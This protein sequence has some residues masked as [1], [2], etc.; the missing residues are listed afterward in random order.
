MMKQPP[1]RPL[2][3]VVPYPPEAAAAYRAAGAWQPG[4]IPQRLR[5]VAAAHGPGR[6]VVTIS[7]TLTYAELDAR[8]DAVA[9]GLL[10][11]GL[12]P[13][14]RVLLQVTN[15]ETAILLWYGLL[16]AGLIPVCTLAIYRRHEI[17]EIARQT[18][19]AAHVVQADFR[20]HDL[21]GLAEEVADEIKGLR[22]II[23]VGASGGPC[24]RIEDM[25]GRGV[26]A[27]ERA[28]L[29]EIAGGLQDEDVAVLQLSGGT[30]GTPKIIPRLHA[31][32]W[33]NARATS[34]WWGH[35]PESLLAL[36]LPVV[37]NAGI[38]NALHA[39]HAVGGAILLGLPPADVMLPLM[40]DHGAT[41]TMTPPGLVTEYMTHPRFGEAV[42]RLDSWMLTAARVPRGVFDA[43]TRRGVH[44]TQA[45]G[46]SEGLFCF[47]PREASPEVRAQTLGRP[48][49][50]LDAVKVLVPGSD[51]EVPDG[52]VGELAARGPYTIRGY[53]AARERNAEAFTA[54]GFYRSGDLVRKVV[55]DGEEWLALAGRVKDL[56]DRGG[57]KVN[58]E[59]VEGLLSRHPGI[60]EVAV[61]AMPDERL[62]ERACA[63]IVPADP[64][65][66]PTLADLTR[67]MEELGAAKY[68]WPERVEILAQLPRTQVGKVT[69]FALRQDIR[70]RMGLPEKDVQ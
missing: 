26:T 3:G 69:K 66:P 61:V 46:M 57:E 37:H 4:S 33:Y 28:R 47:T 11:L 7:G 44:V 39:A 30:T 8:S 13:G 58:A 55:M 43:L 5:E 36:A 62:G 67:H 52:E 31:E 53:L 16:K 59:E 18:G 56:I 6:A 21:V 23:T 2:D 17:T 22:L 14:E 63:Y 48:I 70:R 10:S 50:S 20:G 40:A 38:S 51:R 32:Y 45:F 34:E 49:S 35:G 12:V 19:A 27:G 25:V 42:T 68:K 65:T 41:W 64:S 24:F 9:A 1:I 54:D 15:S 29:L 60:R